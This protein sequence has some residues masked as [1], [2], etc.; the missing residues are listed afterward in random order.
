MDSLPPSLRHSELA[1]QYLTHE[2]SGDHPGAGIVAVHAMERAAAEQQWL[3][4]DTWAHRA[5][6]HFEQ[7]QMALPA[8][9]QTR[10]IGDLRFFSGDSDSARRY[11]TEAIDEARNIGAENEQGLATLGL[12]RALLDLG[13]VEQAQQLVAAAVT[14]LE[15]SGGSEKELAEARRLLGKQLN[16]SEGPRPPGR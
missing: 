13:E 16:V 4:A 12:G 1:V 5:L 3:P 11:Y 10:R 6:W 14:L 7:A 15:R 8:M 2:Q 9:R